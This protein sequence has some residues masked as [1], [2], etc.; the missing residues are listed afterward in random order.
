M[1]VKSGL[2]N[3]AIIESVLRRVT[4]FILNCSSCVNR[5]P[6]YT[7]GHSI[8]KSFAIILLVSMSRLNLLFEMHE[9]RT[10]GIT[11]PLALT[12]PLSQVGFKRSADL[13][14]R[15]LYSSRT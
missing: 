4:R 6:R 12:S 5:R 1:Q 11:S 9:G 13:S 3:S 2:L 15:P 14:M 7:S 10:A 8:L